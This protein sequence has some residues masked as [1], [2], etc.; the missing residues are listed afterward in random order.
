MRIKSLTVRNVTSYRDSTKFRF[1][2]GLN[3]LIGP[4]GGGKSNAQKIILLLLTR[5]FL[6]QYVF[7]NRG[8]NESGINEAQKWELK[9]INNL[10]D[11]YIGD[12]GD[13][14]ICIE[15][16]AEDSDLA[17]MR[18]IAANIEKIRKQAS[19]W[20]YSSINALSDARIDAIEAAGSFT[21]V[22]KNNR[23]QNNSNVA[24]DYLGYLRTFFMIARLAEKVDGVVLRSPVFYFSSA[25]Q[26]ETNFSTQSNQLTE[27][28]YYSQYQS[29]YNAATGSATNLIQFAT[30]HF[31]RLMWKA[32][33]QSSTTTGK[34]VEIFEGETDVKLVRHYLKKLGY[35]WDFTSVDDEMQNFEMKFFKDG[36]PLQPTKFSSGER[37]IFH[38]LFAAFALNVEHGLIVVDEPELH[39]HPRWQKIF[40]DL[41]HDLSETRS[42]QFI[43]ATHSP[44]FVTP[45]TIANI[46]RI[47]QMDRS[48]NIASLAQVDLPNKKDL[49]HIVN[50]H[51]NERL[52]FADQVV[53]VEGISDRL[54][55][56]SLVTEYCR[57]NAINRTVEVVEVSGKHNFVRYADLCRAMRMPVSIIADRDYLREVGCSDVRQLFVSDSA[58]VWENIAGKKSTDRAALCNA[59]EKAIDQNDSKNL[60]EF[61]RYLRGRGLTLKD[62]L[63]C[64]DRKRLVGDIRRLQSEGTY[65]LKRGE[66]EDYLPAGH[67]DLSRIVELIRD[68]GWLDRKIEKKAAK[69]IDEIVC[70]VLSIDKN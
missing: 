2:D 56:S 28:E 44:G 54:V 48:S 31:G 36:V 43:L 6:P 4:N 30:R 13:Q 22:F 15:I 27:N 37:E 52:F 58:K 62:K 3:I 55:F 42:N 60:Q 45:Q 7:K 14:E 59:L 46:T 8:G 25:R 51:N 16:R 65:V 69:E 40:L 18:A 35:G 70:R 64:K 17:N 66:I 11:K 49:V 24:N 5:Y 68:P 20:N 32:I 34:A 39:L 61:W 41:F 9:R 29:I 53:L 50:S 19:I 63:N 12:N 47:F 57:K 23:P 21:Y 38:F 10:L 33:K 67:S 1:G 26:S